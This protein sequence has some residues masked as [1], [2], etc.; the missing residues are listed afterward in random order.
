MTL[1]ANDTPVKVEI[2][3]NGSKGDSGTDGTDGIIGIIGIVGF[4]PCL[5]VETSNGIGK[6]LAEIV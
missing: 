5:F 6:G 4:L 1:S 2:S 3:E